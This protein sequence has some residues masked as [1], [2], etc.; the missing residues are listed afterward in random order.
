M[1]IYMPKDTYKNFSELELQEKLNEDYVI[2][3]RNTESPVTIIAPHG[4]KIEP[5]TSYIAARIAGDK[6]NFYSFEG[7]KP[8]HNRRLHI[9]SHKFDEPRALDLIAGSRIVV[10][11]HACKDREALI[12]PGGRDE[13][14]ITVISEALTAAGIAVA[15]RDTRYLGLNAKNICNRGITGK[16]AQLEVSRGLRDDMNRVHALCDA[17][18]SALACAAA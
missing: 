17:V 2:S 11:I 15:D 10:A 4:G 13:N 18:H 5:Q 8:D 6:F 14:L 9:T 1:V 7:I 16:G 12:Y 3:M